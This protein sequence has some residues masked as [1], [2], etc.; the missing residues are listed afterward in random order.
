LATVRAELALGA[1]SMPARAALG[2]AAGGKNSPW[3]KS[4][5]AMEEIGRD[6]VGPMFGTSDPIFQKIVNGLFAWAT[7]GR[8]GD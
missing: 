2:K 1:A 5:S 4:V 6:V 8:P 7:D 3:F